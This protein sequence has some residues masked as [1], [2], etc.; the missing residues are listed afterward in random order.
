MLIFGK[1]EKQKTLWIKREQQRPIDTEKFKIN[2][3][4]LDLQENEVGLYICKGRIEGTHPTCIPK[5]S[6]QTEKI[7]FVEH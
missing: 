5:E 6:P 2:P 1:I 3:K 4:S 7:I